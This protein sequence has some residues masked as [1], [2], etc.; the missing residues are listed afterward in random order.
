[1]P[2]EI[3]LGRPRLGYA[4]Q[5][6]REGEEVQVCFRDFS[7]T[8]DGQPFI[9]ML[10]SFA[11]DILS[12][13][14]RPV[15]PSQIDHM[16][17]IYQRDGRA[18]VYLNELE[19]KV[20]TRVT[21]PVEAGAAVTKSEVAEIESLDLGVEIPDDVGFMYVFSV[22]WRKGLFFDYGPIVERNHQ[23][24]KYDVSMA[25]GQ[26][27]CHVLFQERFSISEEEW[28][29]LSA[30]RWFP[31]VTL[32]S[33]TIDSMIDHVRAGWDFDAKLDEIVSEVRE[34]LPQMLRGWRN[35]SSFQPDMDVFER[36]IELFQN[37]DFASCTELL[38]ARIKGI[39]RAHHQC[40]DSIDLPDSNSLAESAVAGKVGNDKCLLFPRRFS[41]FLVEVY[42][43]S[44]DPSTLPTGNSDSKVVHAQ[45]QTSRILKKSAL[46]SILVVQQI[47][48]FLGTEG[49]QVVAASQ[50]DNDA[51]D[52]AG[53]IDP[54]H[55]LAMSIQKSPGAYA[56]L[57]GS[58][59]SKA[60]GILTGWEITEDLI[61]QLAHVRRENCEPDPF[62]WYR[63]QYNRAAEY[64]KL[65]ADLAR[66]P[67]ER[68]NLLFTYFEANA[69]DV[70]EGKKQP[71]QAH[72]AIAQ[73]AAKGFLKVII[74]TNF[75]RLLET[76]IR[77]EG[78]EP[79]IL[80]TEDQVKNALPLIHMKCCVLKVHGDFQDP[81]IRNTPRELKD[82]P[83]ATKKLLGQIFEE[84]GLIVCGWSAE[85]D[86]GLSN[87]LERTVSRH[88]TTHWA[89][90]G[91]LTEEARRIIAHR[92][93]HV[94]QIDG[95]DDFFQ[96]VQEGVESA[97]HFS[98]P[99]ARLTN[100]AEIRMSRYLSEPKYQ[101]QLTKL[102]DD[103]L[104][105][106]ISD[107]KSR[108]FNLKETPEPDTES[109][110]K[111]IRAYEEKCASLMKMAV[112]GGRFADEKHYVLWQRALKLLCMVPFV[113]GIDL[114]WVNMRFYPGTLLLYALG[115]GA[116]E[117][118][119]LDFLERLFSTRVQPQF[120]EERFAVELLAPAL[121]FQNETDMK[122]LEGM[123]ERYVPLNDWLF[124]LLR[125]FTVEFI[126]DEYH[127]TYTF[128]KF[129][130]LLALH[131]SYHGKASWSWEIPIGVFRYKLDEASRVIKE[132]EGSISS[133]NDSSPWVESAIF[134]KT[135]DA[136]TQTIAHFKDWLTDYFSPHDKRYWEHLF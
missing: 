6:A 72:R 99:D 66:K 136:C 77:E 96:S 97:E 90:F 106:L 111:R 30:A 108:T 60:A 7:S 71:T 80:S 56:L 86:F 9:R 51:G 76:A 16:L 113:G 31:F 123:E 83:T 39:L 121:I 119:H 130:I 53:S 14:P 102:I 68:Q 58:G 1:M 81:R 15:N 17:V 29:A 127:Y 116:I 129:E 101:V 63:N 125:E 84:F 112:L 131:A 114:L 46:I 91:D 115:L 67:A 107:S 94:I 128:V 132:L 87:E 34:N 110:T 85:Y 55:S 41:D 104:N 24:R 3:D 2:V 22:G 20:R 78:L 18:E 19:I 13:L 61:R 57:V 10:E 32:K 23:E 89:Q 100:A 105:L 69:K 26:A 11:Y 103:A 64:S 38:F 95:A 48:Y 27:F 28:R 122:L 43:V 5:D 93:A 49:D 92:Q 82:L 37:D 45:A 65:L 98:P 12:R 124:R 59:V 54:I 21:G 40:G 88:F 35:H 75:D 74:T 47:S 118:D 117:A 109:V 134:G 44:Y 135:A 70:K 42:F 73:L 62:Q 33:Q 50:S 36:A 133:L 120:S 79:T 8:E 25:L 4:L 126:S 52:E